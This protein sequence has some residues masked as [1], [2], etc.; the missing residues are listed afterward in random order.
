MRPRSSSSGKKQ[1]RSAS[2]DDP[3]ADEMR[4]T[5][6]GN[7]AFLHQQMSARPQSRGRSASGLSSARSNE[8]GGKR[9]WAKKDDREGQRSKSRPQSGVKPFPGI[10]INQQPPQTPTEKMFD[11]YGNPL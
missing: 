8:G 2:R 5:I 11:R 9:P 1:R 7:P 10:M 3:F 6:K 4:E